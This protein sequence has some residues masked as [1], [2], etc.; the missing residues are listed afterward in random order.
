MVPV[1]RDRSERHDGLDITP[2]LASR[3]VYYSV[4][5]NAGQP[6]CE[7]GWLFI[8][9]SVSDDKPLEEFL[10]DLKQV[11]NQGGNLS[12]GMLGPSR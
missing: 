7:E 8:P 12:N 9:V 6:C 10:Q 5:S 11:P 4:G 2:T 1:V 3:I